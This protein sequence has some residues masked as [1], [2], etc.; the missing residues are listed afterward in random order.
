MRT[1]ED[2]EAYLL[3]SNHPHHE[4][5]EATW[6]VGD[7]SG[8]AE[9][10]VLRTEDGL[11]LFRLKVLDLSSIDPEKCADFY[12]A[13]LEVNATEMVHAAY[14]ISDGMVLLTASH[15]LENIDYN[16]FAAVV[17]ELVLAMA[18]H[19]VRLGKFRRKDA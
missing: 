6:I 17:E 10:I 19:H 12:R 9:N 7:A 16:E 2:I 1:R 3:R 18:N 15:L 13:L 14:G 8:S 4:I 5:A 11:C